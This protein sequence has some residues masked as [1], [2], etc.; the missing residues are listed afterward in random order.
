MK[1]QKSF[2]FRE[3]EKNQQQQKKARRAPYPPLPQRERVS[4][5]EKKKVPTENTNPD[6]NDDEE[7]IQG[8]L[9][10]YSI[11]TATAEQ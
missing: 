4:E 5:R 7:S 1:T 10:T 3:G 8:T 6:V 2:W 11:M 9:K